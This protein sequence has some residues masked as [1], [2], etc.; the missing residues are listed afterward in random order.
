MK[1]IPSIKRKAGWL[2]AGLLAGLLA[3]TSV[4]A[5]SLGQWDFNTGNLT[6]TAGSTLGDMQYADGPGADTDLQDAFGTTTSFGI[7]DIGGTPANVLRFPAC[8]NLMGYLITA[9]AG[10]GGGSFVNEYTIIFD[11]FYPASGVTRPL[12]D[13]DDGFTFVPGPDLVVDSA[14]ALG[15]PPNGPY[16]GL[17]TPNAWHRVGMTVSGT[18]IRMYVDGL[19]ISAPQARVVDGLEALNPSAAFKVLGAAVGDAAMGYI[20]SL[21][22][23]DVT[24]NAGQMLALGAPTA[25]G[26]PQTIPPVPSFVDTRTPAPGATGVSEEV[27]VSVVL[28]QGDTTVNGGSIQLRLD[29]VV[30]PAT[31]TPSLPTYTI[32]YTV[33]P[34]L[35]PLSAH[36]LA[37]SWSDNVAGTKTNTWS[38]TVLNYQVVTLPAPFYLQDFDSFTEDPTP[39][40]ALPAGWTVQDQS[41]PGNAGFSLDDRNSDSYEGW[42]LVDSV[43][44]AGWGNQRTDLPTII[45][46]GNKLTTLTTGN[47]LWTESDQRC[48][49]CNGQF[50]DLFTAPI[51]C[52][53]R[54][55][56]YVA[57]NSIYTQ[58]Q[59]NMNF[60]EYSVDGGTSWLPVLYY[61]DSKTVDGDIV[62]TNGVADVP[63]TFAR[64]DPNRNWSPVV[65]PVQ[66]TNY[67]SYIS[68]PISA[69]KPTDIKGR[70]DDNSTD[71]KRIEVVRLPAADGQ[72][73][74][75]FR[76]NA[77]GTSAWFWG[78]DN[79]GLYEINTPV[80]TIQPQSRTISAT[81][82]TNFTVAAT[83]SAPLSY[84]WQRAGANLANGG[85]FSG[86]TTATLTVSNA[87]TNDNGAYRC[88]I[89]NPGGSV[90]SLEANLTVIDAP[91]INT[92]PVPVLVSAGFPAALNVAAAGR[93]PLAYQ[94]YRGSTPVGGNSSAFSVAS[95][96][97]T[98]N[99]NYVVVV[100]NGTGSVTSS[101]AAITVVS[102]PITN[103][104]VVHLKFDGNYND[105]SGRGNNAT[106]TGTPGFGTGKLGQAFQFTSIGGV[107]YHYA[108]LG[109]PTDLQFGASTDFTISYWAKIAPGSKDGDPPMVSNKDWDSG[110]NVGY[111]LG[112]QGSDSFEYNYRE[113]APNTRKDFDS[114]LNMVDGGWHH[115]VFSVQ[116]GSLARTIIDGNL[117]DTRAIVNAGNAP[118]T[119]DTALAVNI[120]QDGAGDYNISVTNGLI[121]DVGFWRRALSP[122]EATAIYNGGNSDKD[123]SQVTQPVPPVVLN[124]SRNGGNVNLT[125]T[126]APTLR[127]QK[128]TSLSP[129]NWAD[130][131]GTT[132]TGS[133]T[134]GT[135]N[136]A[137]YYRLL[138]P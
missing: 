118:T 60:M 48:G 131:P 24:L 4:M 121:D 68:A 85:H 88:I 119:I 17:V 94:W 136:A 135:T 123:L 59:D 84:Q 22:F 79:F 124:I 7:P 40:V 106:A 128:A 132:G 105:A 33:P 57:F 28:H 71:G 43:R 55:N 36:T 23:R 14:G 65:S 104:L 20:N 5:Q 50:A 78:I 95:A 46:N 3:S 16:N 12:I 39:G 77:N 120:G 70:L 107:E 54:T 27:A 63:A 130:V 45:L 67:G 81:E 108:T 92:Q 56:V 64:V 112:I 122:Q 137:S 109:Y 51:S 98:D 129:A 44:L 32:D 9:P 18:Q 58:N 102:G 19:E 6:A 11:V 99:G 91:Q 38:F 100:S 31:I 113:A 83:G 34:R 75:R 97:A 53:G 73:S 47:L 110:N 2:G 62:L 61:F 103:N 115:V 25:A 37:L 42:I 72:A 29:G 117:V 111:V 116:R 30:V 133:Y 93:P 127:L 1:A 80:I 134:D 86:V 8:T 89:S 15:I 82:T 74:V 35:A 90:T 125:W 21:Q 138:N 69:I 114:A 126:A 52:V 101:P 41:A 76:W 66:A 87:D 49:G 96:S 26:I 10:N 13:I